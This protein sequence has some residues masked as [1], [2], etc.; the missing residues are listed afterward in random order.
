MA[1]VPVANQLIRY[2]PRAYEYARLAGQVARRLLEDYGSSSRGNYTSNSQGRSMPRRSTRYGRSR[3]GAYRPRRFG[4]YRRGAGGTRTVSAQAGNIVSTRYR[5]TGMGNRAYGS[6]LLR[7][8]MFR[9]HYRSL[10]TTSFTQ[11]T[12]IGVNAATKTAI[13]SLLPIV[14]P[15]WTVAGG[16]LPIDEA[17]GV[18]TFDE[19]TIV[20]RGG[21]S[22]VTVGVPGV[23]SVKLK[24]YLIKIKNNADMTGFNALTS[25]PTLWDPSHY[26]DFEQL[27]NIISAKE[28]I[29]LPG[30]RP[31]AFINTFHP[32]KIDWDSYRNGQEHLAYV[33]TIQQLTDADVLPGSVI[34]TVS[35]SVSFSADPTA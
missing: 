20:L 15:F 21:R 1:L 25:V 28:Y 34:F 26:T 31:L 18:P 6:E 22:E 27:F 7:Q 32:K 11:A 13:V 2:G 8:T 35:H 5:G 17:I 19:S 12:P 23:D 14:N 4:R 16:A 3:R 24:V 33:F 10:L 29:M 30:S 9:P